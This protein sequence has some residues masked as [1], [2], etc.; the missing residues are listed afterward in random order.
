[1]RARSH[2]ATLIGNGT[3]DD[4][5]LLRVVTQLS[6]ELV[7]QM[8]GGVDLFGTLVRALGKHCIGRGRRDGAR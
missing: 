8:V 2:I 3:I 6:I 1:M 5:E 7:S 4:L